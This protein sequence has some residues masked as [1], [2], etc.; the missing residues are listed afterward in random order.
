MGGQVKKNPQYFVVR[1]N[2][3]FI[4]EVNECMQLRRFYSYAEMFRTLVREEVD[5]Q[6]AKYSIQA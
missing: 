4:A 3:M 1:K 6:K 5:R 2:A